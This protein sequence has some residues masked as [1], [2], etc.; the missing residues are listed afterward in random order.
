MHV[1]SQ[2]RKPRNLSQIPISNHWKSPVTTKTLK[3]FQFFLASKCFPAH[4][5]VFGCWW[6]RIIWCLDWRLSGFGNLPS[7]NSKLL[8]THTL[9]HR[10]QLTA[11][12]TTW[13]WPYTAHNLHNMIMIYSIAWLCFVGLFTFS[14][15]VLIF[16]QT[17]RWEHCLWYGVCI[18]LNEWLCA[19]WNIQIDRIRG[20]SSE[21]YAALICMQMKSTGKRILSPTVASLFFSIHLYIISVHKSLR[22]MYE[23][24]THVDARCFANAIKAKNT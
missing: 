1:F 3:C 23:G 9:T 17:A 2:V 22:C 19:P 11:R 4:L 6:I 18:V 10:T 12:T 21:W 14:V 24:H 20:R 7:G 15:K 8:H 13:M 5:S 16:D